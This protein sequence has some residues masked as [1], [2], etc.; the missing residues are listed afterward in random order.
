M[1]TTYTHITHRTSLN[2]WFVI[3]QNIYWHTKRA[4]HGIE[5]RTPP[6]QT[7]NLNYSATSL[8][9]LPGQFIL[10][11]YIGSIRWHLHRPKSVVAIVLNVVILVSGMSTVFFWTPQPKQTSFSG[12]SHWW[13]VHWQCVQIIHFHTPES[14][15]VAIFLNMLV[16]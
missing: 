2:V 9:R 14:H 3:V 7:H 4:E 10:Y 15:K 8:Y 13:S 11:T 6:P 5:P 12:R 1:K 16:N